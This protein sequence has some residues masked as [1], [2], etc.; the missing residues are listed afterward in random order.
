MST[1]IVL[2]NESGRWLVTQLRSLNLELLFL[3][4][5]RAG[6]SAR[7]IACAASPVLV[8]FSGETSSRKD[9]LR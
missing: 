2:L 1:A 6:R 8:A 3:G 5:D 7:E 9:S 4:R